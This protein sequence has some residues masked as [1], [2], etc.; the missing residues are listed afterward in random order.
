MKIVDRKQLKGMA[1]TTLKNEFWCVFFVVFIGLML[2]C[3]WSGLTRE[4]GL[5]KVGFNSRSV[6]K[7]VNR[8]QNGMRDA[9]EGTLDEQLGFL[10]G[11]NK[12]D[13]RIQ[14]IYNEILDA[15]GIT[16]K[17]LS[18][19][20]SNVGMV[21]F[22]LVLLTDGFL[23][24]FQFFVGS[25]VSAPIRIGTCR[26][27][28]KHR[29]GNSRLK[30]L[31]YGFGKGRYKKMV[32]TMF[33]TNFYMFVWSLL[34]YIPGVIGYYQFYFVP[35]IMAENKEIDGKRAREISKQLTNGCKWQ[36]FVLQIS[37]LGWFLLAEILML[38]VMIL[39][40][41]SLAL[42]SVIFLCPVFAYQY[43]TYAELYESRRQ[44]ALTQGMVT[45]QELIGFEEEERGKSHE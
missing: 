2:G 45:R 22:L 38:V 8:I 16:H 37:F 32:K 36:M 34:L 24:L 27:F 43:A 31:F 10:L 29:E 19:R 17:E 33:V 23:L 13:N 25:L 41:F 4:A 21:V 42:P 30:D 20:F 18:E 11:E 6:K 39:S 9:S 40:C 28:M 26:F 3:N 7:V 12:E 35:Y 5:T 15:L 44:F 1:K 14:A